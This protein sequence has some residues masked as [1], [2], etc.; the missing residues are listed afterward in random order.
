[1]LTPPDALKFKEEFERCQALPEDKDDNLTTEME[2]LSVGGGE[3]QDGEGEDEGTTNIN[4]TGQAK[5]QET[6]PAT[7]SPNDQDDGTGDKDEKQPV[8][9]N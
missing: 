2:K 9:T 1:M 7:T 6:E 5:T 3:K 4:E 8:A